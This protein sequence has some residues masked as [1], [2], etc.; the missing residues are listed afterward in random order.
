MVV[1]EA[2]ELPVT[3]GYPYPLYE[4]NF[5]LKLVIDLLKLG[6]CSKVIE[7]IH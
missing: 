7:P 1:Q 6:K 2:A 4:Q 3:S 5:L